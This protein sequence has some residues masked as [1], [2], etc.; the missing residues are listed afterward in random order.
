MPMIPMVTHQ[1]PLQQQLSTRLSGFAMAWTLPMNRYNSRSHS[2]KAISTQMNR[3]FHTMNGGNTIRTLRHCRFM[4]TTANAERMDVIR[5]K[6][7]A[8]NDGQ[9]IN[10]NSPRQVATAIFGHDTTVTPVA[11]SNETGTDSTNPMV[12]HHPPKVSTNQRF[13]RKLLD[14]TC[15][16]LPIDDRQRELAKLVMQYRS[17]LR[18]HQQLLHP[19]DSNT[20]LVSNGSINNEDHKE[21]LSHHPHVPVAPMVEQPSAESATAREKTTTTTSPIMTPR[22]RTGDVTSYQSVVERLFHHPNCQIHTY[23]KEALLSIAR[24]TAQ[25]LVAQ[26]DGTQCPMGYDP[27]AVPVDP[28]LRRSATTTGAASTDTVTTTTL[29]GKKGSFLAFY[30]EQKEKYP[31][32]VIL[33]RCGDFYETFGIDAILLVEHCGL[34]PMANKAKAG[35]PAR[36]VQATIDGLTTLGFRVAVY[37]EAPDTDAS[38]GPSAGSKS[39]IK[40]R[41]LSQIVCSASPTYLYDLVLMD[42]LADA[43][44]TGPM[45]RP[46]IGILSSQSG[47]TLVEVSVEERTVRI[48]E[49]LTSEAVACRL[50]ACPPADPLFYVPSVNEYEAGGSHPTTSLILPFLPSRR[51]VQMSGPGGRIRT[52]IL[53][54]SLVMQQHKSGSDLERAKN[55]VVGA[56]LELTEFRDFVSEHTESTKRSVVVDDYTIITVDPS[57][58]GTHTNALY[59]E[60]AKQLGLM[61]DGAIPSLVPYLVP[62]SAP[63]ATK[64]FLRRLL[65]TPPPPSVATALSTLITLLMHDDGPA[66]PP[67]LVPPLGKILAMIRAGQAGAHVYGELLQS[68]QAT[69]LI[70]DLFSSLASSDDFQSIMAS[71]MTVLEYESGMAA[72]ASSLKRRCA[73]AISEIESVL[74]PIY[75]VGSSAISD[76]G[77]DERISLC[78]PLVPP[79]FLERNEAIWRGRVRKDAAPDAYVRVQQAAD[80][81]SRA[82]EEDFGDG[83][84]HLIVQDIFNNLVV[85]KDKPSTEISEKHYIHPKDRF[86]KTIGNRYTT[87]KVQCALADYVNACDRAGTDVTKALVTLSQSLHDLGHM[88]AIVQASHANLILST[89]F[90]HAV[91]ATSLGW[92]I[93]NTI[94][95]NQ[96]VDTAGYFRSVWPYWM[97]RSEAVKNTFDLNGMWV[98]T[99]PNMSGKST[100]MRS[101]AAAALLSVCGLCAPLQQGSQI[102]RFDHIFVRGASSDIPSEQKSAFGAEMAD[103]A[104]LLRCCTSKSLVFVDELGRGTSPRDGTRLSGAVLEAMASA[105]MSGI[106][107]THLHDILK[108]PLH[109]FDRITNK[110]M[111]IHERNYTNGEYTWTYRL[112]D[113]VCTDSLALITAKQFGLPNQVLQRAE[114]L[115]AFLPAKTS[116]DVEPSESISLDIYQKDAASLNIPQL[117]EQ[118]TGQR[119]VEIAPGWNTPA[120]FNGKSVVYVLKLNTVPTRYYIGESDNIRKRLETHRS[121]G[122]GYNNAAAFVAVSPQGK[123]QSRL[124]EYRLIRKMASAGFILES[125]ADGRTIR[126]P[127]SYGNLEQD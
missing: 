5:A 27:L 8:L 86:G 116:I 91:K 117:V 115:L 111:A 9:W 50:A 74:C 31:D 78:S 49:R 59:L 45:S 79:A 1:H 100:I 29:A 35:C 97:E 73:D 41:F 25:M 14:G 4:M 127:S 48:S 62:D 101:T 85:L 114:A 39:R 56:L 109:S 66:I 42:P 43:L 17:L 125:V 30:R 70:V 34:N 18:Q 94:E 102:R 93:A 75:H 61:N 126:A 104:A 107:A 82:F 53:P 63:V 54:P 28:L 20:T 15:T 71:F 81:L 120:A 119:V 60:T 32:C 83:C 65:L 76:L 44:A 55:I 33:T 99:A 46:Y 37:E 6:I 95:P 16:D 38:A 77:D 21:P 19:A 96:D 2:A 72:E 13:L 118:V 88:P 68:L 121:K 110:R 92:C 112:E 103:V 89:L 58:R 124:W 80:H 69:I 36:N 23:W 52:R 11:T 64:R 67:L 98:L 57:S 87:E 22:R 47:Y 84:K 106:F 122:D 7:T 26:L 90:Y 10:C 12:S 108:L 51:D 40:S 105:G 123:S 113:G 24:P 3:I